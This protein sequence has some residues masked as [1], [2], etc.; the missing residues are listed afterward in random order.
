MN[1]SLLLPIL[2]A[3]LFG[4]VLGGSVVYF[5]NKN[6]GSE[7]SESARPLYWV[8]P[9]DPTYRRDGPGT[10]PMGMELVPVFAGDEVAEP[11][12]VSISPLVENNLGVRTALVEAAPFMSTIRTVGYVQFDEDRL[13][14]LH[15]RVEGWIDELFV[16]AQG[17]FI[18]EGGALYSIY[19]PTLVNAQEELLLAMERDNTRLEVSAE[20]RLLALQV[21]QSLIDEVKNAQRVFRNVTVYAPQSGL[22]ANLGVRE[23]QFVQPGNQILSIG[24]LDEVWVIAEVFERQVSLVSV[25]DPVNMS[26]DYLPGREWQGVVDFIY[27]TLDEQTRTVAVRLR[28]LNPGQELKPNMFAQV[29]IQ[30]SEEGEQALLVPQGAVI[31][32][33]TQNRVVLALG[34]GKFKSVEVALGRNGDESIEI[35]SGLQAGDRVVTSAHFLLDSES[36]ITSDFLRMS[37]D[38]AMLVSEMEEMTTDQNVAEPRDSTTPNSGGELVW[39]RGTVEHLMIPE[40]MISI[41]HVPVPQWEWPEMTMSFELAEDIDTTE[42]EL[43]KEYEFQMN[44]LSGNRIVIT[45]LLTPESIQ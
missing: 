34:E 7:V 21:P 13:I 19:S 9:M 10:S 45:E 40:R 32:T 6:V 28:F 2:L 22:V 43:G 42:I 1:K 25:G 41:A 20:E 27:P 3:G 4:S 31:R 38:E 35:L 26:L 11:G 24:V 37:P 30:H 36:N 12:V 16:K 17:E 15:P 29:T 14:N 8:S 33:G 39:S 18:D 23:G 5:A 44:R